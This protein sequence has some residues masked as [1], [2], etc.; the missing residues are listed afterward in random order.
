MIPALGVDGDFGR[1][2][3]PGCCLDVSD[4]GFSDGGTATGGGLCGRD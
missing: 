3:R 4:E 1:R 2:Q